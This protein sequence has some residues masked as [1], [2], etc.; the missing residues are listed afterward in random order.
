MICYRS[1]WKS[2]LVTSDDAFKV[3]PDTN[4]FADE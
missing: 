1:R 4:L 3:C 2:T